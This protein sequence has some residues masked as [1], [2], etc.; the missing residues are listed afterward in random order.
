MHTH[1]HT[2]DGTL[3]GYSSRLG[4]SHTPNPTLTCTPTYTQVMERYVAILRVL[5]D[6][7]SKVQMDQDDL[8]VCACVRVCV[9]VYQ[10]WYVRAYNPSVVRVGVVRR[11]VECSPTR[12]R[13]RTQI[14]LSPNPNENLFIANCQE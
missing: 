13:P 10:S 9:C 8:G 1:L 11:S 14:L 5:D 2:G 3:R 7:N 4:P 6:S 12:T